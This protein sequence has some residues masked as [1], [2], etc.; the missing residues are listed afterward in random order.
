[1]PFDERVMKGWPQRVSRKPEDAVSS[2]YLLTQLA[3]WLGEGTLERHIYARLRAR[4]FSE[5]CPLGEHARRALSQA[6]S[7]VTTAPSLLPA[8]SPL[9]VNP[10]DV[11]PSRRNAL[12]EELEAHARALLTNDPPPAPS[13]EQELAAEVNFVE[14]MGEHLQRAHA[15]HEASQA[16]RRQGAQEPPSSLG[17]AARA[18]LAAAGAGLGEGPPD[19]AAVADAVDAPERAAA[20]AVEPVFEQQVDVALLERDLEQRPAGPWKLFKPFLHQNAL[21]LAGGLLVLFG[22]L[23]FLRTLW[24]LSSLL[25]YAAVTVTLHGY[26]AAFFAVGYLLARRREAHAVGRILYCFT[27]VLLPLA[28]VANGELIALLLRDGGAGVALALLSLALALAAQG[29]LLTLIAGLYER[30]SIKP[31][32]RTTL[33]LA[34]MTMMIAALSSSGISGPAAALH[35]WSPLLLLVGLGIFAFGLRDLE[36]QRVRLREA[37]LTVVGA[38]LWAFVTMGTRLHVAAPLPFTHYAPL[39]SLTALL[40]LHRDHRLVR[41]AD[42]PARLRGLRQLLYA[43]LALGPLLGL[44]G[45][46]QRGYFDTGARVVVLLATMPAFIGYVSAAKR[47]GRHLLT[48]MAATL[49]LLCYFFL[50]A[51]FRGLLVWAQGALR[52]VL[53]YRHAPLPLAYYG[54]TFLPYLVACIGLAAYWRRRH[55]NL[56]ADLQRFVFALTITLLPLASSA[57]PDLRPMLWTWPC[58]AAMALFAAYLFDR[59]NLRLLAQTLILLWAV[60]LGAELWQSYQLPL[61]SPIVAAYALVCALLVMRAPANWRAA[62]HLGALGGAFLVLPLAAFAPWPSVLPSRLLA[63]SFVVGSLALL[64]VAGQR[65][66]R[67]LALV[68]PWAML[69]TVGALLASHRLGTIVAGVTFMTFAVAAAHLVQR[70]EHRRFGALHLLLTQPLLLGI[71]LCS[72]LSLGLL[73]RASRLQMFFGGIILTLVALQL[74]LQV[75]ERASALAFAL[76]LGLALGVVG[77]ATHVDAAAPAVVVAGAI[78]LVIGGL[79][80]PLAVAAELRRRCLLWVGHVIALAALGVCLISIDGGSAL[81]LGLTILAGAFFTA[82]LAV[83]HLRRWCAELSAV[84]LVASVPA[85]G[86]AFGLSREI[87]A[88]LLGLLS[89][90]AGELVRRFGW[91]DSADPRAHLLAAPASTAMALAIAMGALLALPHW[92][93]GAPIAAGLLVGFLA[94]AQRSAWTASYAVIVLAAASAQ[95]AHLVAREASSGALALAAP[96]LLFAAQR[97]F[98]GAPEERRRRVAASVTALAAAVVALLWALHSASSAVSGRWILQGALG[99][100]LFAGSAA[101][102]LPSALGAAALSVAAVAAWGALAAL[103]EVVVPRTSLAQHVVVMTMVGPLWLLV[104]ARL[105]AASLQK[106]AGD[107]AAVSAIVALVPLAMLAALQVVH[108]EHWLGRFALGAV[109]GSWEVLLAATTALV[110]LGLVA[111]K[112]AGPRLLLPVGVISLAVLVST[113]MVPSGHTTRALTLAALALWGRKRWRLRRSREWALAAAVLAL[114]GSHGHYANLDLPLALLATTLLL[115]ALTRSSDGEQLRLL[116]VGWSLGSVMTAQ[117]L[118]LWLA[119]QLSTGRYP[120]SAVAALCALV[121]L[122][123]AVPLL[124]LADRRRPAVAPVARAALLAVLPLAGLAFWGTAPHVPLFVQL[125][126]LLAVL[127]ALPCWLHGALRRG[128]VADG[129]RALLTAVVLYLLARSWGPLALFGVTLDAIVVVLVGPLALGLGARL[130]KGAAILVA[131]REAATYLPLAAVFLMPTLGSRTAALLSLLLAAHYSA[132]ARVLANKHLGVLALLLGNGSLLLCW[133]VLGWSSPLLVIVPLGVTLLALLHVYE[134]D[135]SAERRSLLRALLLVGLY[136]S[137]VA[138][139]CSDISPLQALTVVPSLCVLGIM[140]GTLLRIRSYLLLSVVFLAVDLIVNML[141]YGLASRTLGALFLTALGLLLV[142]AMVFFNLEKERILRRY[143]SIRLQL[144]G[145]D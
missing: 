140:A 112:R 21:W 124:M 74:V 52:E 33:A 56:A 66:A 142:A 16:A 55:P 43:V 18:L 94:L 68:V 116:T 100:L 48:F 132:A 130:A 120:P 87:V 62:A 93:L 14:V 107:I 72:L 90:L 82:A 121:A 3:R 99:A 113:V 78:L 97:V 85:L 40:L 29:L 118:T 64:L 65:R 88:L 131:L 2:A 117:A 105:R 23:Y 53:G 51:P 11:D 145:W 139:A 4:V 42:Q 70:L 123:S 41:N 115:G 127:F 141:R 34:L 47:Y 133:S 91:H 98:V 7:R 12:D 17:A 63:L 10:V 143:T 35:R 138:V 9:L 49:G 84:L 102:L 103:L 104:A 101:A 67:G 96:L 1:M 37:I 134:A 114:L 129:R 25:W 5:S 13:F 6:D 28:S 27:L 126:A 81:G 73:L 76:L 38:L 128:R 125:S 19:R 59:P 54:L 75:F 144:R 26:A 110:G 45:L 57:A 106:R 32:L 60:V 119:A 79:L 50:P 30:A 136:G 108:C 69:M 24:D 22:S 31:L 111:S 122:L 39:V 83:V 58:Y 8:P 80:S 46:V 77:Y 86:L 71:V 92:P 89:L 36:A 95:L 20:T 135:V 15:V 137:S 109:G 44:L 61:A